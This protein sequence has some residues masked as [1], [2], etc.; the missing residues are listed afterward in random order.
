[1]LDSSA[2]QHATRN[3]R[4]FANLKYQNGSAYVKTIGEQS[5]VVQG[6][7]SINL[8]CVNG[9]IKISNIMYVLG[10]SKNLSSIGCIVDKDF[11]LIFD[12]IKCLF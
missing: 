12:D 6:R 1:L 11:V 2:S 4:V 5:L 9:E 7:G 8:S 3:E 10:L